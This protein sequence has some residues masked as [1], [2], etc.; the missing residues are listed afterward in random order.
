MESCDL[1]DDCEGYNK[2]KGSGRAHLIM[3]S[4]SN[5]NEYFRKLQNAF[6]ST[7]DAFGILQ[8]LFMDY[9]PEEDLEDKG[10]KVLF[11]LASQAV[12]IASSMSGSDKVTVGSDIF[13]VIADTIEEALEN[14]ES[15]VDNAQEIAS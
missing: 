11:N 3:R 14:N 1:P 5:L 10:L 4:M 7:K 2:E 13:S 9:Y 6:D 12:G 15:E 8:D